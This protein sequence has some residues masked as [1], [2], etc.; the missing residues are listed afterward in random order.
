[1]KPY[2]KVLVVEALFPNYVSQRQRWANPESEG[3]SINLAR[4]VKLLNGTQ[5]SKRL[6]FGPI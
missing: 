3:A 4:P 2:R 6:D 1:M 5:K